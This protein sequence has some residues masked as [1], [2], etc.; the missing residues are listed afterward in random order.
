[1]KITF[2]YWREITDCSCF[3]YWDWA[4][5]FIKYK[6]RH[7]I[8]RFKFWTRIQTWAKTGGKRESEREKGESHEMP[9]PRQQYNSTV[10]YGYWTLKLKRLHQ[11]SPR[12]FCNRDNRSLKTLSSFPSLYKKIITFFCFLGV[13]NDSRQ[14]SKKRIRLRHLDTKPNH[15]NQLTAA[16][17]SNSTL[18]AQWS[19]SLETKR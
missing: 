8:W 11:L 3:M 13:F 5:S 19:Y 10:S 4:L 6:H 16:K 18:G 7:E 1:M 9:T 15:C 12:V 17:L 14:F 2:Q